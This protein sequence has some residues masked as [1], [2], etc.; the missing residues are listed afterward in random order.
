MSDLGGSQFFYFFDGIKKRKKNDEIEYCRIIESGI[1]IE[2]EIK[3]IFPWESTNSK[4]CIQNLYTNRLHPLNIDECLRFVDD[5]DGCQ[6]F[7]TRM[8]QYMKT[9]IKYLR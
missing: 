9:D 7:A 4:C 3:S 1:K 5:D 2:M 6:V 8:S